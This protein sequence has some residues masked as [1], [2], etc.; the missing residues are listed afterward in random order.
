MES[1]SLDTQLLN[2]AVL[3]WVDTLAQQGIFTTDRDLVVRSWNRWLEDNTGHLA[4]DMIGR[5][6][7]DVLPDMDARGFGVYYEGAL[8]GQLKVLAHGLHR[9]IVPVVDAAERDVRQ[10]GRITPLEIDGAVVGTVTVIEDVTERVMNERELRTQIEASDRARALAE[11][12]VQVKDEFLTTLSHEIRT[13]LNAVIGWA[14]ILLSRPVDP[15]M[16]ARALEVIDRNATAQVR[17]IDDMLDTARIM[18]GK[19]R[20]DTAPVDLARVALAAIDVV[21][22]TAAA[23]N[24]QLRADFEPQGFM[25]LGD[26]DRLQQIIWN[27]LANAVKFTEPG[28]SVTVGIRREVGSLLL[29][30]ADTG[31]GIPADF[32]PVIFERFRQ[33]DP[34]AS[35]RHAGLGIGLSLVR[36]LVELH[37]G[38]ISVTSSPGQGSVFT[39][40]FPSRPEFAS[41]AGLGQAEGVELANVRILVMDDHIEGRDMLTVALEQHGARVT[42]VAT[43]ADALAILDRASRHE[44]PQAIVCDVRE[45]A[46]AG[47]SLISALSAR[48]ADRG[49]AIPAMA[50]TTY[51][52]P[53]VKKRVLAAGFHKHLAKPFSPE[54]LAVAVRNLIRG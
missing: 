22:P 14:R 16:L 19:L 1:S 9:Y 49:R 20:L 15:A 45:A 3:R 17:L 35:R 40:T 4:A 50:I 28:G 47:L 41:A 53:Q 43:V 13:P 10:S 32:M 46:D 18:S 34:S 37:G 30:V 52:H 2:A 8:S 7:F 31:E 26:A 42:A 11:E 36:Q 33:A 39:V 27:L 25:M 21:A 6:L 29:S 48:P 38:R 44:L 12:A 24:V 5:R 54:E 51:E 23:K